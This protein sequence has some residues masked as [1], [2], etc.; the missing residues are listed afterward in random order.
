MNGANIVH[1]ELKLILEGHSYFHDLAIAEGISSFV[2]QKSLYSISILL[3][4]QFIS[5][6]KL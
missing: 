5:D 4:I 1:N 6:I 2:I 3:L